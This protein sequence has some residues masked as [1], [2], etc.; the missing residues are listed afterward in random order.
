[1]FD[2]EEGWIGKTGFVQVDKFEFTCTG[3]HPSSPMYEEMSNNYK[4]SQD[5]KHN[6][7]ESTRYNLGRSSKIHTWSSQLIDFYFF[8]KIN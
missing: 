5:Y 4:K 6:G 3:F 1:M 2:K 8:K 7:F